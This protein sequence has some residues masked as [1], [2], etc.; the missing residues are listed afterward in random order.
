[1]MRTEIRQ[2]CGTF[3]TFRMF[4]A[5]QNNRTQNTHRHP[6]DE[7]IVS[8]KQPCDVNR[9]ASGSFRSGQQ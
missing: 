8:D 6:F 3:V 2:L 9:K 7:T 5:K 4:I 1:M